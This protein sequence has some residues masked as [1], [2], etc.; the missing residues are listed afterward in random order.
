MQHAFCLNTGKVLQASLCSLGNRLNSTHI[1]GRS[2]LP[3]LCPSMTGTQRKMALDGH[4]FSG[5]GSDSTGAVDAKT[6]GWDATSS[7]STSG[8]EIPASPPLTKCGFKSF[9]SASRRINQPHHRN[10]RISSFR[11]PHTHR[12]LCCCAA[13]QS[14]GTWTDRHT[15]L[16]LG[17]RIEAN[18]CLLLRARRIRIAH[19]LLFC[20]LVPA[21]PS[22]SST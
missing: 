15:Y 16:G 14:R 12:P 9:S 22:P 4:G 10:E 8:R 19:R 3:C 13:V 18:C 6:G 17:Q 11:I 1:I 20:R 5:Q 7:A 2:A 21:F